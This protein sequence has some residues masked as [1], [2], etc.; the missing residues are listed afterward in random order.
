M[1]QLILGGARSGKSRLAERLAAERTAGKKLNKEQQ[2]KLIYI[3]TS[4][5]SQNDAEM[6]DRIQRHQQDRGTNWLTIEEPTQLADTLLTQDSAEHS[7]LVDCTTLW[8][9]NCLFSQ[10]NCWAQ[11]KQKLLDTLPTLKADIIFVGNE[12]GQGIIPMGSINRSFVDES[13][14]LHQDLA[15]LCDRVIFTAAG[16]PLVLKGDSL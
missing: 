8:L 6:N 13:G 2:K 1:K 9:T 5:A 16:L 7:I 15:A 12:V 4:D 14:W 11:Q 3:A 10:S